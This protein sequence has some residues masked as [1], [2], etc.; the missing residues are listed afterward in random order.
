MV[1]IQADKQGLEGK[2]WLCHQL[3][4]KAEAQQGCTVQKFSEQKPI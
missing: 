4:E 3:P 1:Y 2:H